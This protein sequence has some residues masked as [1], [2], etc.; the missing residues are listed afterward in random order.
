MRAGNAPM[1]TARSYLCLLQK[2]NSSW[3]LLW[4]AS[5]YCL[6][7]AAPSLHADG[8]PS[9]ATTLTITSGGNTVSTIDLPAVV[10]LTAKTTVN[11]TAVTH[12]V[13]NFCYSVQASCSGGAFAGTAQITAAG[14][15]TLSLRSSVGAHSYKAVFLGTSSAAASESATSTLTVNQGTTPIYA[16]TT[17]IAATGTVGDYIGTTTVSGNGATAPTGTVTFNDI[18]NANA[19]VGTATLG[20]PQATAGFLIIP[21]TTDLAGATPLVSGDFNGDGIPDLISMLSNGSV[22]SQLGNGD[23]T[24]K[25]HATIPNAPGVIT[26]G[27]FNSDGKLDLAVSVN[28]TVYVLL[29]DGAGGFSPAVGATPIPIGAVSIAAADFNSDGV[30]DLAFSDGSSVYVYTGVGDGTFTSTGAYSMSVTDPDSGNSASV[31][32]GANGIQIGDFNADGKTDVA[33]SWNFASYDSGNDSEFGILFLFSD[34]TGNFTT[35]NQILPDNV[36]G[37]MMG[38]DPSYNTQPGS[39][40]IVAADL[41]GDGK[42]DISAE[43]SYI[44]C[45]PGGPL[46]A[47]YSVLNN[48]D[49]TFTL[50]SPGVSFSAGPPLAMAAVDLNGD[51]TTQVLTRSA[52]S[53]P[54]PLD[55]DPPV[56]PQMNYGTATVVFPNGVGNG[57]VAG[58]FLGDGVP[59]VALGGPVATSMVG[60]LSS[61]TGAT[62]QPLTLPRGTGTN[63]VVGNY[64][65]DALHA[66]STSTAISLDSGSKF[67]P[68]ITLSAPSSA[69]FDQSVTLTAN[70]TSTSGTPTGTVTFLTGST[71]LGSG[72]LSSGTA[73]I[74][75]K[76][77]AGTDSLTATYPGDA[78]FTT[79]TSTAQSVVV[80]KANATI[81]LAASALTITAGASETLTVTLPADDA[82]PSG[83]VTFLLGTTTLGTSTVS[84]GTA[85]FTTSTLPAGKDSITATWT[86]DASYSTATSSALLISV[87]PTFQ[88]TSSAGTIYSGMSD[89]ITVTVTQTSGSPVPTG[90]VTLTSGTYAS[91]PATLSNGTATISIPA[92]TLPSGTITLA[93]AYSGDQVYPA[94]TGTIVVTVSTDPPPGFT[95]SGHALTLNA[96]TTTGNTVTVTLTPVTGFTGTVNLAAAV[97]S[98][99]SNANDPPTLSFGSSNSLALTGSTPATATLTIT[100][101]AATQAANEGNDKADP[102]KWVKRGGALLACTVLLWIPRR[103]LMNFRFR[104]SLLLLLLAGILTGALGACSSS[105]STT[106]PATKPGTTSGAYTITVTGTSGSVTSSGTV[107]LTVQ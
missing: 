68:S 18:T 46:T 42:T 65:G 10:T 97:T 11:G 37:G 27:D 72:T 62:T 40:T 93:A 105:H 45:C 75:T 66:P 106:P 21:A 28:S 39:M 16:T 13:I 41:N 51:G 22:V 76:L 49:G 87:S 48:G 102:F 107:T 95:I 54:G 91:Q 23:G 80:S 20:T 61:A 79:A 101:T 34:G 78:N 67:T 1:N 63:Q 94:S 44:G 100:T 59:V 35:L 19:A 36:D 24:F 81:T 9:S 17:T 104:T 83:T 30:L 58:D 38:G 15:A 5:V 43:F 71:T 52:V 98:S 60:Y 89:T 84:A 31:Y 73:S 103:K 7:S 55:Q 90:T 96:G 32:G 85:T 33:F 86:G 56:P 14:T 92:N 25:T 8:P 74:T 2:L 77:P 50:P 4:V 82:S 29:G 47:Y 70:V 99:P 64:G 3:K 6:L 26:T 53:T 88:L 57:F 12:G 69:V